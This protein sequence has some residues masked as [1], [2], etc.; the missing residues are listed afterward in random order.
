MAE[1]AHS[2][3]WAERAKVNKFAEHLSGRAEKYFQQH[4]QRWWGTQPNLWFIMEQ[5]NAAFHVNI[6]NRQDM[7]LLSSEKES[8][9]TWN[10]H[11]LYLNAVTNASGASPTLVLENVVKYVKASHDG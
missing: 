7:K 6:S 4:V 3:R 11:F 2:Y 5:M 9:R 1:L 10:D 8:T